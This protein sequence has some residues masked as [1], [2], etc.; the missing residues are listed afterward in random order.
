MAHPAIMMALARPS[1]LASWALGYRSGTPDNPFTFRIT[2][3]INDS[4]SLGWG[5]SPKHSGEVDVIQL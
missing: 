3:A 1:L 5:A 4:Y 2:T